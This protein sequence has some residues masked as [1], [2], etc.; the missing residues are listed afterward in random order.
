MCL[1]NAKKDKSSCIHA[2]EKASASK[3]VPADVFY[4]L[5]M[6]NHLSYKFS[7]A[8]TAYQKFMT[9]GK[10]A[11]VK[12]L[13]IERE[14]EYCNSGLKL[15]NNPVVIEVFE[16]KH[17]ELESVHLA[18]THLES[19]GKIL[20]ITEDLRSSIDKKKDFKCEMYLSPDKSTIFYTS[21]GETEGNGK[22]IYRLKKI[23]NKWS[24]E[25]Y[26]VVSINSPYDEEYP[27]LSPDGKTLYFSSKGF[28]NMGGYD[29]FRSS[30]DEETQTWSAPINLGSPIN[31]PYDD[32]YFVE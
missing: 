11:D 10:A 26:N 7:S 19:G 14:I 29:I 21:Y 2:L 20:M 17:I 8:I 4:Y 24:P 28:E 30:W 16:K 27:F 13:N 22:D 6:A 18:F 25:P 9:L 31:S 3:D 23:G 1:Y 12:K 5:G 15:V 32:I